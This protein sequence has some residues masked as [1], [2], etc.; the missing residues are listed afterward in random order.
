LKLSGR[1]KIVADQLSAE[2]TALVV[3]GNVSSIAGEVGA[4]G[5]AKAIVVEDARLENYSTTAYA[6]VVAE[7]VG[8]ESAEI[9][10][11]PASSLGKD[12]SPRVSVKIDAGLASECTRSSCRKW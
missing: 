6:K 8:Q 11:F 3:G 9:V 12:L 5:A 7:I 2:V 1:Q 4:Y 10:F